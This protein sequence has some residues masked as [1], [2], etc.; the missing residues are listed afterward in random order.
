MLELATRHL[1][2][3]IYRST[4]MVVLDAFL[5]GGLPSSTITEVVGPSGV[6][7]TQFCHMISALT[8]SSP[9]STSSQ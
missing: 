3:N 1:N 8:V 5:R 2:E 7:K 9:A 4:S 6:G